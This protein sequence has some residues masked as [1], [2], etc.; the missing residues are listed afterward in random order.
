M[1]KKKRSKKVSVNAS[2]IINL[3]TSIVNLIVA[4]MLLL[5]NA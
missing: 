1:G 2:D 4:L 5:V 3:I